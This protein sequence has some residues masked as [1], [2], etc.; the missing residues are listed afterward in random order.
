MKDIKCKHPNAVEDGYFQCYFCEQC[1]KY[2]EN[3]DMVFTIQATMHDEEDHRIV[4]NVTEEDYVDKKW[5]GLSIHESNFIDGETSC[6][7]NLNEEQVM[8]LHELTGK[9]IHNRNMEGIRKGKAEYKAAIEE[10]VK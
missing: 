9:F 6:Y 10:W 5:L 8:K 7:I 3:E 2:I 4:M 1:G